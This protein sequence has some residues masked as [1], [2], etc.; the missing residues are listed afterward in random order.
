MLV[1]CSEDATA[2]LD[3]HRLNGLLTGHVL[4]NEVLGLPEAVSF[5]M[6]MYFFIVDVASS[7]ACSKSSKL[8]GTLTYVMTFTTCGHHR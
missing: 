4:D 6:A 7:Y 1:M 8:S 3:C 2:S 5:K